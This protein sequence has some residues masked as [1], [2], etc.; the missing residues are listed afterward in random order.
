VLILLIVS[1]IAAVRY[2]VRRGSFG[3]A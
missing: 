2:A 3:T 1:S